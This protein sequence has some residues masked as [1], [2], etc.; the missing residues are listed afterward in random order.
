MRSLT[1]NSPDVNKSDPPLGPSDGVLEPC[2]YEDR[3][4]VASLASFGALVA[5]TSGMDGSVFL[6]SSYVIFPEQAASAQYGTNIRLHCRQG[7]FVAFVLI[8][9]RTTVLLLV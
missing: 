9:E 1:A 7:K 2:G 4:A 6:R 8:V 3:S 5:A